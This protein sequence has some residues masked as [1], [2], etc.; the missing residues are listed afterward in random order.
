MFLPLAPSLFFYPVFF[1]PYL[2]GK[3]RRE[4]IYNSRDAVGGNLPFPARGG[5]AEKE[6]HLFCPQVL[7]RNALLCFRLPLLCPFK[8]G[9]PFSSL[10]GMTPD[11]AAKKRWAKA[12]RSSSQ[13]RNLAARAH[14][15]A[16]EGG[17]VGED[18]STWFSLLLQWGKKVSR[19]GG[20]GRRKEGLS[21][22]S[23]PPSTFSQ[24][25]FFPFFFF[26]FLFPYFFREGEKEKREA[27]LSLY[28][29]VV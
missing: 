20:K 14:C 23:L 19:G 22:P 25:F 18:G 6:K 24:S 2:G 10:A 12:R 11:N 4:I 15:A 3:K 13:K 21:F 29:T 26:S 16:L 7:S 27:A 5:R 8:K 1:N 9:A 28:C 17:K